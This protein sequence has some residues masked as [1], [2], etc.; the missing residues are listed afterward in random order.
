MTKERIQKILANAGLASRR[1]AETFILA[2]RVRVNGQIVHDLGY[3]ADLSVDEI[4]LDDQPVKPLE[5]PSYYMFHKP[6][7]YLTTLFDPYGRPTIKVFLDR[8]PWRVYP[9]G[10]LDYDVSG[11]LILTND[12]VLAQRLMHPSYAVPKVYRAKVKGTLTKEALIL[13]ASGTLMIGDKPAAQ[14]QARLVNQGVDQGWLELTLTEGRHRQVKHMCAAV[15]HPVIVLKRLAYGGL[16]LDPAL[17]PGDLRALSPE[18]ILTL[19][20]QAQ[21]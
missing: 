10:R 5:R 13:L 11:V 18:E 6:V 7:G 1:R 20:T 14:A 9:I 8:L 15:G 2:G 12:G 21:L 19:K 3:K 17:K 16:P 4:E